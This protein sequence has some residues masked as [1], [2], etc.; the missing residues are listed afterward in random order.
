MTLRRVHYLLLTLVFIASM[1]AAFAIQADDGLKAL[2][3]APGVASLF[4]ALFQIARDQSAFERTS[5]L[6]SDQQIFALGANS[7]M[8]ELAFDK[9][10]EF[11]E[12][13]MAE[14]HEVIGAL[15]REGTSPK[16]S[17]KAM[18][19]ANIRREFAAW[20]TKSISLKLEPFENA[21]WEIGTD[22]HLVRSLG[23][24][25]HESRSRAIERS[26]AK[27]MNVIG[28]KGSETHPEH[29][30]A[31][32]AENVKEQVRSILGIDE[33]TRVREFIIRR[34]IAFIDSNS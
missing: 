23:S 2:L 19:L 16:A 13:Y 6:Q 20:I 29:D 25:D 28:L 11:C 7:H 10:V 31:I 27:L 4:L 3:A 15:F 18:S 26:H 1:V 17:D 12:R 22:S 8:A 9:H 24:S 30:P 14:L 5:H 21:I 32:A 34:S 33:L